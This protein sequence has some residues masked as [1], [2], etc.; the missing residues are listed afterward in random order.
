MPGWPYANWAV[1]IFLLTVAAML[2]L[3]PD[4]RVA[5]YLAP[6]WFGLLGVGYWRLSKGRAQCARAADAPLA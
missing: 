3:D 1:V 5:L 6:F 2:S 4:T